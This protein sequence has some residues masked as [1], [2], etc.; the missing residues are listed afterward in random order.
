MA[1]AHESNEEISTL[2]LRLSAYLD[3]LAAQVFNLE[4]T[5]GK[6]VE[7]STSTAPETIT[8]LQTLDFLRQSLEDLAMM[9]LLIAKSG[10]TSL[11]ASEIDKVSQRLKLNATKAIL[12]GESHS[13]FGKKMHEASDLDLF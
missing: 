13:D 11:G 7:N 6:A 10:N 5:I 9:T 12:T 1:A 2:T 3:K 4:E 8:N